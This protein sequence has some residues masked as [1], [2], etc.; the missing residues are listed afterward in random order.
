LRIGKE[1]GSSE[2]IDVF[3]S[4]SNFALKGVELMGIHEE[5]LTQDGKN[6]PDYADLAR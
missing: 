6:D 4:H 5:R 2:N 3:L 1:N